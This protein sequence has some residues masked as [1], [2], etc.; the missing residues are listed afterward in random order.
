MTY[1]FYSLNDIFVSEAPVPFAREHSGSNITYKFMLLK[2]HI[3]ETWCSV[4]ETQCC[5][6]K[7]SAFDTNEEIWIYDSAVNSGADGNEYQESS[8]R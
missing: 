4:V 3:K 1:F 2:S 5:K 6:S 7:G 8:W